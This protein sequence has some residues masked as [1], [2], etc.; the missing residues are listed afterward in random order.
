MDIDWVLAITV[1]MFFVVWS[2]A[3]YFSLFLFDEGY[4]GVAA[5]VAMESLMDSIETSSYS[6]P[7]TYDSASQED[8]AVLMAGFVWYGGNRS[9][10]RVRRGGES[11][12]CRVIGNDTYWLAN[13]SSGENHFR[14][15]FAY[16]NYTGCN[17]SFSVATS[18]RTIPGALERKVMLSLPGVYEMNSTPYDEFRES[19]GMENDFMVEIGGSSPVVYGKTPPSARDVYAR[20]FVRTIFETMEEVNVT[21][22][23][24]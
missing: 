6:V 11:L 24:W 8:D 7:V 14:I 3:F 16:S 22:T 13:L 4:T 19:M 10:T 20:N 9:T 15:E 17:G 2:F 23:V 5:D 21:F 18:Y 1:F 12:D